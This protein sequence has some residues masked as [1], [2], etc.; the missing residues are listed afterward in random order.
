[1]S[2]GKFL[3]CS[4]C[5]EP[6]ATIV[7]YAKLRLCKK[8]FTEFIHRKVLKTI[9]R[10][11]LV[12][13]GCRI[14]VAVSGGKDSTALLHIL[15]ALSKQLGFEVIA[16]HIDLGIG[17]YSKKARVVVE[18]L[19]KD[20]G[21]P[22]VLLDL[23]EMIGAGITDLVAKSKRPACSLCGLVKR[24][25]M[26]VTAFELKAHAIALGH[27]LDDLLPYIV[28]NF[29]L[30]NLSEIG[31][32]GP[33]TESREVFIGRIRPLYEVSESETTLYAYFQS[34]PIVDESCPYTARKGS[35]EDEI[36]RFLNNVEVKRPGFKIAFA[37]AVAKNMEF[38]KK[39]L[40]SGVSACNYCGMPALSNMCA[41]CKLTYRLLGK[42][43]GTE[44]RDRIRKTLIELKLVAQ[45]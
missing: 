41:F 37:R 21:V 19:C 2:C 17:E 16:L 23:K 14:L 27:H 42:P 13:R 8:H 3:K 12:E 32:L 28:K 20:L 6:V 4:F 38:Y 10:Y 34:L 29:V 39:E 44:I 31:K 22:L 43:M 9:E 11:R 24:Y 18:K 25:L 1:M 33:K 5:E 40:M 26:N 36:R 45:Q 35:I 15:S 30:Q 7:R